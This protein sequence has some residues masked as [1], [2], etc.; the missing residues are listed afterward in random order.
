MLYLKAQPKEP[1]VPA[2]RDAPFLW[3]FLATGT[4]ISCSSGGIW[5]TFCRKIFSRVWAI[6]TMSSVGYRDNRNV[7]G[8]RD[9]IKGLKASMLQSSPCYRCSSL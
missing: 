7:T 1:Q 3:L 5:A 9:G 8:C 6:S 2:A 4:T